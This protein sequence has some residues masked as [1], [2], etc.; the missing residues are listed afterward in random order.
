MFS[1]RAH[2]QHVDTPLGHI[3]LHEVVTPAVFVER[4]G[5]PVVTVHIDIACARHLS[6]PL[7][8]EE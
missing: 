2:E 1:G 8:F 5:Q 7:L 6:A 4:E 3:G